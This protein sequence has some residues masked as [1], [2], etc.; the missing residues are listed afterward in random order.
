[1]PDTCGGQN[2]YIPLFNLGLP[3]I[4][5]QHPGLYY[6]QAAQ[7]A[8]KRRQLAEELCYE[9][10]AYPVPDPLVDAENM[11]FYGQRPWRPGK[12]AID[13]G[14]TCLKGGNI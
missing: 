10:A 13:Y 14:T 7:Y 5:T 4:Q 9:A 11:E 8:I 1:M 2:K 3:A 12:V 6:Q